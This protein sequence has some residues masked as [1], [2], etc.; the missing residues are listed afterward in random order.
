MSRP[1][2]KG[3]EPKVKPYRVYLRYLVVV[4]V[5]AKDEDEAIE[6]AQLE[7]NQT[8]EWETVDC[9]VEPLEEGEDA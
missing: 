1:D 6:N 5:E 7:E 2:P 9:Q 8:G 4:D 3:D